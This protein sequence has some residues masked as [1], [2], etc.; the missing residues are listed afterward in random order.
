MRLN[1]GANRFEGDCSLLNGKR[2]RCDLIFPEFFS[3]FILSLQIS[4]L[5]FKLISKKLKFWIFHE[6]R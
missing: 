6:I 3:F 5:Y 4:E 1:S 2:Y